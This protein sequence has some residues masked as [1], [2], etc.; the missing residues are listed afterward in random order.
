MSADLLK[1]IGDKLPDA[2]RVAAFLKAKV[3]SAPATASESVRAPAAQ[4]ASPKTASVLPI[5]TPEPSPSAAATTPGSPRRGTPKPFVATAAKGATATLASKAPPA[6][7][8][9]PIE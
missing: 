7:K 5:V 8:P 2:T 6:T 1:I 3:P 9:A 4:T